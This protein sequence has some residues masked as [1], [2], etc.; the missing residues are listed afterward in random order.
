M[1]TSK[2]LT[3]LFLTVLSLA[4][5]CSCSN[6]DATVE[7]VHS[8]Q[9]SDFVPEVID[10]EFYVEGEIEGRLLRYPQVNYEW[11]NV[12]NKYFVDSEQTWLQGIVDE[13]AWR[14]RFTEL[15]I[16]AIELP[17][18]LKES[19]GNITWFDS[20]IDRIIENTD[21]CQG[22]DSGCTFRLDGNE[23]IV[24]TKHSDQILEGTFSGEAILVRTGFTPGSD[25]SLNHKIENGKFRIKYRV[26]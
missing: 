22:V 12:S 3:T 6:D 14:I 10:Y 24:I 16:N 21:Y 7:L 5:L 1:I 17:Y 8:D 13:G 20:R 19:E 2:H 23:N 15:D 18:V 9:I 25:E 4:F 26:E 11:T